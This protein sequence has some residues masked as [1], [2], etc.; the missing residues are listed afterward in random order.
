MLNIGRMY[1]VHMRHHTVLYPPKNFLA[2][3]RR[4][5]HLFLSIDGLFHEGP[6]YFL[7][8]CEFLGLRYLYSNYD[9][10]IDKSLYFLMFGLG[11]FGYLGNQ[12]H[13]AFHIRNHF[14]EKFDW[15]L[16]LRELH[17]IHH[18]G[19]M[20][21]NYMLLNFMMDELFESKDYVRY[22]NEKDAGTRELR[23]NEKKD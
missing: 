19:D 9:K 15:F 7:V 18:K 22:I 13:Y 14:M 17:W 16:M 1:D 23:E 12:L 20:K 8:L 11:L 10:N 3:K 5:D 2:D 4:D 21:K 6:L